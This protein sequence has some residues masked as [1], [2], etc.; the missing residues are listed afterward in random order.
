MDDIRRKAE[1]SAERELPVAVGLREGVEEILAECIALLHNGSAMYHGWITLQTD[2]YGVGSWHAYATRTPG[3]NDD[4]GEREAFAFCD[5]GDLLG[6]AVLLREHL[7][8][9]NRDGRPYRINGRLTRTRESHEAADTPPSN[10]GLTVAE[11]KNE[12]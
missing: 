9:W 2:K 3:E 10:K 5:G 7:Q 11:P 4:E 1:E 6:T 8:E 12:D